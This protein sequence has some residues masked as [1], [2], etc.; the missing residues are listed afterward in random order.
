MKETLLKRIELFIKNK[1]KIKASFKWEMDYEYPLCAWMYASEGREADT[2]KMRVCLD[3]LKKKTGAFSNFRG[4]PK[5]TVIT[6]LSISENPEEKME[7]SLKIYEKLKE[8][9]RGSEQLAVTAAA[10]TDYVEPENYAPVAERARLIYDRMKENHPY[11]TSLD[12]DGS[13]AVILALSDLD[14]DYISQES[15]ACY[16][17]LKK[18]FS[19]KDSVQ[20]LSHVLTLGAQPAAQKCQRTLDLYQ[21]LKERKYKF[22]I[23]HELALLGV[24]ALTEADIESLAQD[25]ISA[26]DY[27]KRQKDFGALAAIGAEQRLMYAG[28]LAMSDYAQ[29]DQTAW[30][31]ASQSVISAIIA[32]HIAMIVMMS[33]VN[34]YSA[35]II[36]SGS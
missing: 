6:M 28:L 17:T 24:L 15:E 2:D 34:S 12:D 16:Q 36:S 20:A 25:I 35:A 5:M 19:Y 26:D 1:D 3:L 32:R 27:L 9:L 31:A 7:R 23:V 33:A 8:T 14:I 4:I 11:L 18:S 21:Y 10:L 22:G 13:F 30:I 29:T